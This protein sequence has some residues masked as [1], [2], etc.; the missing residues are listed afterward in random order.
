MWAIALVGNIFSLISGILLLAK[1][2]TNI[3][4]MFIGIDIIVL[5]VIVLVIGLLLIKKN[6][7]SGWM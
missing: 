4:I 1:N 3:N 5:N 6:K 7:G 2:L